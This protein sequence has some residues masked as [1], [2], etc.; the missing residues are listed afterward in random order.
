MDIKTYVNEADEGWL[1]SFHAPITTNYSGPLV[2]IS[3]EQ[4]REILDTVIE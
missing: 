3:E 2:P 1:L 4:A